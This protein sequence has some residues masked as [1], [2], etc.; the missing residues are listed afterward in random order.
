MFQRFKMSNIARQIKSHNSKFQSEI[1]SFKIQSNK[2]KFNFIF[3]FLFHKL[4][5]KI[6]NKTF[7]LYKNFKLQSLSSNF[8]LLLL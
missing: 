7:H 1:Q 5:D 2:T 6:N 4:N 3:Y 8:L